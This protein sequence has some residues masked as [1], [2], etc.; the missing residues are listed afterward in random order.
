MMKSVTK[1]WT[2]N[3]I[4]NSTLYILITAHLFFTSIANR[5][6][7]A[8]SYM[9]FMDEKII[10]DGVARILHPNSLTGFF[11]NVIDGGDQRYGRILWNLAAL[12][13]FV[14]ER[15]FGESG[16]IVATRMLMSFMVGVGMIILIS[17]LI[18]N[19]SL[20]IIALASGLIAPFTLY[21]S[22]MPKP[23]PILIL[24]LALFVRFHKQYNFERNFYWIFLG[25][26]LGAKISSLPYF[27]SILAFIV[28]DR[29]KHKII[30]R[31]KIIL[32]WILI[33]FA[34]SVPSLGILCLITILVVSSFEKKPNN[35]RAKISLVLALIIS[36]I[37]F[38]TNIYHYLNWTIFGS[39]H[40]SDN[41][42]INFTSWLKFI[43]DT[44]FAHVTL[45]VVTFI[46]PFLVWMSYSTSQIRESILRDRLINGLFWGSLFSVLLIIID[47]KRLW[48]MYLWI[49]Y[50]ILLVIILVILEKIINTRRI[51]GVGF[52][53]I[54]LAVFALQSTYQIT[55]YQKDYSSL[56]TRTQQ[57]SFK[58][59]DEQY[60][61]IQQTLNR[62]SVES[63]KKLIVKFDP[64]L[65]QPA[66]TDQFEIQLFWGPFSD[67]E[68]ATDVLI[69]SKYH[70]ENEFAPGKNRLDFADYQ[71]EQMAIEKYLKTDIRLC[72]EEICYVKYLA[73]PDRG[74]IWINK[75]LL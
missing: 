74:S 35:K 21:Y 67:W 16:Q 66:N 40:G 9:L 55:A 51:L 1:N 71:K 8:G 29:N 22:S 57:E 68:S 59:Q 56:T 24:S 65:F 52:I 15:I 6:L 18:Q 58:I 38:R 19:K 28:F 53:S 2:Y 70:T 27:I 5:D 48:G 31:I 32:P 17:A 46:A 42:Q 30:K 75:R 41:S 4:T 43:V 39:A 72:K 7:R 13:S 47:V 10:F 11:Q 49:S 64:I 14:P 34:I 20:R 37:F 69:F 62:I 23:E 60:N 73:L 61:L 50:Y 25:I 36:A 63:K 12:V 26:F 44:W 45:F 33:G 3:F 54:W